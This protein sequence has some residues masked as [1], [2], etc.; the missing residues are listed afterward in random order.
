MH[1]AL[2]KRA[3]QAALGGKY[4]VLSCEAKLDSLLPALG[5][6]GGM[7]FGDVKAAGL[8]DEIVCIRVLC[9]VPDPDAVVAGLYSILKPGGRMVVCEHV[10]NSRDRRRGG[11]AVGHALQQLYMMMGWR[12]IMGGCELTRDTLCSL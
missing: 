2:R 1:A 3:R 8:F 11:T 6:S 5:G 7:P 12:S 10:V 4:H 9:G